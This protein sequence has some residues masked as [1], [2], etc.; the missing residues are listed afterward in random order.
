MIAAVVAHAPQPRTLTAPPAQESAHGTV[1]RDIVDLGT[2]TVGFG[3]PALAGALW[4]LP[5]VAGATLAGNALYALQSG[6]M[7]SAKDFLA[8]AAFFGVLGGLGMAGKAMGGPVGAGIAVALTTGLGLFGAM[9]N[10]GT[11]GTYA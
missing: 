9:V 7:P 5:G 10:K 3:G 1:L 6:Q 2:M 11:K 4:G 8:G